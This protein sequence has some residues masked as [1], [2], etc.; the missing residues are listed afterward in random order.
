MTDATVFGPKAT[1]QI[2]KTVR[3]VARMMRNPAPQRG[4]YTQDQRHVQVILMEDLLAAV[5]TLTDPSTAKA[6]VLAK[7]ANG[8]LEITTREI[9]IVNRFLNI[10]IDSGIYG[11]AE[12]IDGEWQLY[13][14]DCPAQSQSMMSMSMGGG[15]GEMSSGAPPPPGGP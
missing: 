15:G 12:W 4:R 14:A 7:K 13:A 10:S 5:D 11:K 9:T 8:D 1:E 3:E 6:R 2:R